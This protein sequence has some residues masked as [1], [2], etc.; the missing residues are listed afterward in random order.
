MRRVSPLFAW[1]LCGAVLA[2][3]TWLVLWPDSTQEARLAT[4][5][6]SAG[7]A[8]STE[9]DESAGVSPFAVRVDENESA[10]SQG[11]SQNNEIN[12]T[13]DSAGI[14][15]AGIPQPLQS[16]DQQLDEANFM[17]WV[18]QLRL[19]PALLNSLI[20]QFRQETDPFRKQQIADLLGT[21]GGEQITQLASELVSS[22]DAE[23][24][25]LGMSLLQDVQPGN[26]QAR[27]MVSAMLST[28]QETPMLIDALTALA[29]PGEVD[30][31]SR[32]H[33]ADQVA[34]L[35]SHQDDGV[36]SIS[37]DVLSRWSQDSQ[38]TDILMAGLDDESQYVRASAAYA[39]VGRENDSSS[40]L[41]D[42]LF[43][44]ASDP[45]E[46]KRVKRAALQAL[47]SMS[48]TEAQ[49]E[50]ASSLEQQLNTVVR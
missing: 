11:S 19:D 40:T 4:P 17:R 20:D 30:D 21:I 6:D 13:S 22:G 38:Y 44:V 37:L 39:L 24:R 41:I 2:G 32:Q 10:H 34:L 3:L 14:A 7:V 36:R 43:S 45:D 16:L 47:R 49:R 8:E 27:D 5:A 50:Q 12:D 9:P 15:D 28:E 26:A 33:L 46:V 31:S 48:L 18:E 42:R 29:S 25:T 23:S 1:I 35:T